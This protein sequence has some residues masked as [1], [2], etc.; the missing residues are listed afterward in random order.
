MVEYCGHKQRNLLE[1]ISFREYHVETFVDE[2]QGFSALQQ[3]NWSQE[4]VKF[5]ESAD[6]WTMYSNLPCQN[7]DVQFVYL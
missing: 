2:F 1:K 4:H 6:C 3:I 7:W 5:L